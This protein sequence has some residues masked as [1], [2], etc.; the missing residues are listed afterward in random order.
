MIPILS[1][2]GTVFHY[3]RK[4]EKRLYEELCDRIEKTDPDS[5]EKQ[6]LS[7]CFITR[8]EIRRRLRFEEEAY[9]RFRQLDARVDGMPLVKV[10]RRSIDIDFSVV[11]FAKLFSADRMD[12]FSEILMDQDE[13]LSLFR[14]KNEDLKIESRVEFIYGDE[15]EGEIRYL[16]GVY[17][18]IDTASLKCLYEKRC[19]LV[20]IGNEDLSEAIDY[21]RIGEGVLLRKAGSR[22]FCSIDHVSISGYISGK[23]AKELLKYF[24]EDHL[25]L[26]E[27]AEKNDEFP[28]ALS[29]DVKVCENPF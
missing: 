15:E 2:F 3:D 26:A 4:Q 8:E 19:R 13:E 17:C 22:I 14:K 18:D 27:V 10:F 7:S 24:D 1:P 5:F 11:S 25:I 16:I 23:N 21:C 20:D 29:I 28:Y 6:F 9:F 12:A